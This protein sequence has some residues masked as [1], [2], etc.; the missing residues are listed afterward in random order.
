MGFVRPNNLSNNAWLVLEALCDSLYLNGDLE[1]CD[2]SCID[3]SSEDLAV[4]CQELH[5]KK[6][7]IYNCDRSG[8]YYLLALIKAMDIVEDYKNKHSSKNWPGKALSGITPAYAGNI[9]QLGRG[10]HA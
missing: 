5:D 4:A 1:F 8:K 2:F 3:L 10:N 6:F 9:E 7:A